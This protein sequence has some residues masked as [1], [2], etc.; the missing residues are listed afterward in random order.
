M[1]N[2]LHAFRPLAIDMLST[3]VFLIVLAVAHNVVL[4]TGIAIGVGIGQI[5]FMLARKTPVSMMQWASLALVVVLGGATLLTNDARFIMAKPTIVYT[6]IGCVMLVPGWLGRYLPPIAQ[7]ATPRGAVLIAGYAWAALMF[8]T[9]AA[10]LLLVLYASQELWIAFMA[11]FPT[12]SKL[13]AFA[14]TYV[15]LRSTTIRAV[16]AREA[17][18]AAAGQATV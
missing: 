6:A 5:L 16:R 11:I 10:N 9:A 15:W 13:V 12:A 7:G 17:E 2:L 3:I 18:A 14:I 4:A 8:A 1:K